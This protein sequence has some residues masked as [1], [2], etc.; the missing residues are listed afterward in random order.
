[1]TYKDLLKDQR[2]K[3]KR[4][5]ILERDRY[6]CQYC[7]SKE[8]LEVHHYNYDAP[9]PWDVR[10]EFLVTLCHNCHSRYHFPIPELPG[11]WV[12]LEAESFSFDNCLWSGFLRERMEKEGFKFFG[13]TNHAMLRINDENE[14]VLFVTHQGND[15]V[16]AILTLFKKAYSKN[17]YHRAIVWTQLMLDDYLEEILNYT[18]WKEWVNE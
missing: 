8:N 3:E 5:T 14:W 6:E 17:V 9:T 15:S 16:M 2:W 1:M 18:P 12:P 7:G 13:E 4:A 10:D 11:L